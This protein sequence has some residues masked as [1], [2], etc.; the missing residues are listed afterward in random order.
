MPNTI[1]EKWEAVIELS[2]LELCTRNNHLDPKELSQR[3]EASAMIF[4]FDLPTMDNCNS[5]L[6]GL[7]K[8]S[9]QKPPTPIL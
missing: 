7:L 1:K 4:S 6:V 8:M 2:Q 5:V 3:K 9:L